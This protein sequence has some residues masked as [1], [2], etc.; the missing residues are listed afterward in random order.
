MFGDP[1]PDYKPN[2]TELD[3][4]ARCVPGPTQVRVAVAMLEAS[5]ETEPY[6]V[7]VPIAFPGK[8]HGI[9]TEGQ[10]VEHPPGFWLAM[11]NGWDGHHSL[12]YVR[13]E[14]EVAAVRFLGERPGTPG[15]VVIRSDES[16]AVFEGY[17]S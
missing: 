11:T 1:P 12:A 7:V 16:A 6:C 13:N 2:T 5:A 3:M 10:E 17:R 9:W 8:D 14:A 15:Y 4:R